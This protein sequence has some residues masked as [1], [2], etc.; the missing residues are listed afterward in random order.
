VKNK[1]KVKGLGHGSSGRK[2]AWQAQ[3][4][5]YKGKKKHKQI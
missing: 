3:C 4:P 1:L 5:E 2:L